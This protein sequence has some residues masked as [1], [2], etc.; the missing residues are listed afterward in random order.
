[1]PATVTTTT[2]TTI[3]YQNDALKEAAL[4]GVKPG[5]GSGSLPAVGTGKGPVAEEGYLGNLLA[6]MTGRQVHQGNIGVVTQAELELETKRL[7]LD[8]A[9]VAANRPEVVGELNEVLN[10]TAAN[11]RTSIDVALSRVRDILKTAP[12]KTSSPPSTPATPP[13]TPTNTQ[14]PTP[15]I[16][17]PSLINVSPA[18]TQ[19]TTPPREP[20]PQNPQPALLNATEAVNALASGLERVLGAVDVLKPIGAVRT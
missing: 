9:K 4:A 13:K 7:L 2:T 16:P 10:Q 14:T 8:V 17:Q 18:T 1:M 15:K 11:L 5:A 12:S 19:S 20:P 3:P 6:A